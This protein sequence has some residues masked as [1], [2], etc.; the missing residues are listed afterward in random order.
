MRPYS[1][2][3]AYGRNYT[4]SRAG[5]QPWVFGGGREGA[6][7]ETRLRPERC[8]IAGDYGVKY[9]Q[10][11]VAHGGDFIPDC[12]SLYG[13]TFVKAG[14][15]ALIPASRTTFSHFFRS[16]AS[17]AASGPDPMVAGS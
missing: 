17:V 16:L 10:L 11:R 9:G 14:Y 7:S 12:A 2:C 15:S 3:D 6:G 4:S 13:G 8:G 5:I 1:Y